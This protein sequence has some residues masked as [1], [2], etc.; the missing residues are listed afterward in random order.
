MKKNTTIKF[1]F[2][3]LKRQYDEHTSRCIKIAE[4][5]NKW[6]KKSKPDL[7]FLRVH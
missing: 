2:K 6:G 7:S 5:V 4:E 3:E 1:D